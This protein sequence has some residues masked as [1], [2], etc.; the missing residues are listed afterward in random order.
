MDSQNEVFVHFS[1]FD[2]AY[3]VTSQMQEKPIVGNSLQDLVAEFSQRIKPVTE[4]GRAG[5]NII[6]IAGRNRNVVLIHPAAALAALV[7]S[8]YLMSDNLV[9]A[10]PMIATSAEDEPLAETTADVDKLVSDLDVLPEVAQKA[11]QTLSVPDLAKQVENSNASRD[12]L[13][14][15]IFTGASMKAV[16]LSLSLVALSVGLPV[17]VSFT[18]DRDDDSPAHKL[19]VEKLI[20]LLKQ[21]NETALL[22][23]IEADHAQRQVDLESQ[24]N[25]ET[26]HQTSVATEAQNIRIDVTLP[27]AMKEVE[28][29]YTLEAPSAPQKL[30]AEDM[31]ESGVRSTERATQSTPTDE[32]SPTGGIE[33]ISLLLTFDA[34][35]KSF[36]LINLGRMAHAELDQLWSADKLPEPL[37]PQELADEN[38]KFGAFD[39]KAEMYLDFLLQTYNYSDI[40]VVELPDDVIFI[41]VGAFATAGVDNPIYAKSWLSDGGTISIVGFKSDMAEFDL[42]A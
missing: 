17:A 6:S 9:A 35:F 18:D 7:W 28:S 33:D 27:M 39:Q 12:N 32:T 40:K 20:T 31:A 1:R 15:A 36:E 24:V 34:S 21:A 42:V 38:Q 14:T 16:G 3:I 41:H 10:A 22:M 11:L 4:A 26:S 5:Q 30:Q 29:S 13:G 8:I 23:E 37:N 25:D 19:T 2:G